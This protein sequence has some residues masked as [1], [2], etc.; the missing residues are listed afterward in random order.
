MLKNE[1]VVRTSRGNSSFLSA[2]MQP[3]NPMLIM[4]SLFIHTSTFFC[5][6]QKIMMRIVA[7][8]IGFSK[9]KCDDVYRHAKANPTRLRL[10]V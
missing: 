5:G 1:V 2:L 6:S 10:C 7:I 3:V 9:G 4:R 8:L